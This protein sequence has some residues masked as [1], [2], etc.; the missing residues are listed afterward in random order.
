MKKPETF[1]RD[2]ILRALRAE[3]PGFWF[4]T[5]GSPLQMSGLPDIVGCWNGRFVG[6]EV[7][8]PGQKPTDLQAHRLREIT[9]AGGI[10]GV[11]TSPEEALRLLI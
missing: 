11:V 5:H 4:V 7:K 9:S 8:V 2:R 1:L 6:L 3:R 10:A